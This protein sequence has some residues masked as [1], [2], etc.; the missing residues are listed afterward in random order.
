MTY[1]SLF[2]EQRP[3]EPSLIMKAVASLLSL[4]LIAIALIHVEAK[5]LHHVQLQG[6]SANVRLTE[7]KKYL[8][9]ILQHIS[10]GGSST[11]LVTNRVLHSVKVGDS[12]PLAN[13]FY[14]MSRDLQECGC[15]CGVDTLQKIKSIRGTF[16]KM[17]MEAGVGKAL[18]DLEILLSWMEY[19]L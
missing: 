9:A 5:P 19:H 14:I 8:T 3:S 11:A 7:L 4:C 13:T 18:C 10:D 15:E 16:D 2:L 1:L 12:S 6:C 17:E